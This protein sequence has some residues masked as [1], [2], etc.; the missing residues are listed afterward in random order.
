MGALHFSEEKHT[1]GVDGGGHGGEA[2][3]ALA[4][5]GGWETVVGI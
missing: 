3:G 2:A 1:G 4:R 5:E